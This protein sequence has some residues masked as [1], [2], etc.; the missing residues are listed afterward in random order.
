[1]GKESLNNMAPT[2]TEESCKLPAT[3]HKSIPGALVAFPFHQFSPIDPNEK[4]LGS[5]HCPLT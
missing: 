3:P 1:M 5:V 2:G 4:L